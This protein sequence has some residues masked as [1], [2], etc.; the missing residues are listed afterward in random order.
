[1]PDLKYPYNFVPFAPNEPDTAS[2]PGHEEYS[3][4]S[5]TL[6]CTLTALTPL[7]VKGSDTGRGDRRQPYYPLENSRYTPIIPGTSLKGMVRSVFEVLTNSC[8]GLAAD[9]KRL[10]P[11]SHSKCEGRNSLCPA[12]RAFGF[13]G[14]EGVH[15]GL[16]NIGQAS[17]QGDA[18]RRSP[19]LHLPA[20]YGPNVT[21]EK[22]GRKVV[23]ERYYGSE[24]DPN[25]RKFYLHHRAYDDGFPHAAQKRDYVEPLEEG[26]EFA[27]E[28]T[29]E[30]LSPS[31]LSALV[32]TLTLS[33]DAKTGSGTAAVRHKLG[34][35]KPTGLGSV[36]I[37]IERAAL[38]PSPEARYQEFG[39]TPEEKT[40]EELG[41]WIDEKQARF[42]NT[43]RPDMQALAQVLRWPP[44]P[45]VDVTYDADPPE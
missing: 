11:C 36:D 6:D 1:M 5:G 38:E 15:R 35:G 37:D 7:L 10:I 45:E 28:V 2:P 40:G 29:F 33:D 26:A 41:V 4:Q 31:L 19:A 24:D 21:L 32:A 8:V 17:L 43:S 12:C 16:I 30:N 14:S 22:H 9:G 25:G 44:D 27:F 18:S 34:Y 39:A 3:G 42:F 20:L 23:N 13:L